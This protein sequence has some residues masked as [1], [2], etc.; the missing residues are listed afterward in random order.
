MDIAF[1]V[2]ESF[3]RNTPEE[4]KKSPVASAFRRISPI[5]LKPDPTYEQFFHR[6]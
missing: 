5:R 6:L 3:R 2:R 4:W 1:T